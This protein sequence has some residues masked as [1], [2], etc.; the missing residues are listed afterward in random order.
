M[1]NYTV[2]GASP[3]LQYLGSSWNPILPSSDSEYAS[4]NNGTAIATSQA[5]D[6]VKFTFNGTAIW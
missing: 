6:Y 3:I 5:D 2:D 4:Y 1:V